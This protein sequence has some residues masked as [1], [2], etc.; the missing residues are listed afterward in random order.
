MILVIGLGNPGEKYKNTRHNVAWIIF[1][2]I[3]G[4]ENWQSEKYAHSEILKKK[5]KDKD[6]I[7][8]KP[9]TFM[10]DSGKI[11]PYFVKNFDININD[12]LVIQ[13]EIDLPLG[14]VKLSIDSGDAGH[15]GVKSIMNILG[16]KKF[17]RIR[18]GVSIKDEEG[19]VYKPDVLGNFSLQEIEIL[20]KEIVSKVENIIKD[21]I[22]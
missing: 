20:K 4:V 11:I 7:F 18:I 10:N 6:F 19:N 8:A 14:E 2:E 15:N 9:Q 1:D 21:F 12:I 13:D 3:F 17:A 5:I 16:S 22:K